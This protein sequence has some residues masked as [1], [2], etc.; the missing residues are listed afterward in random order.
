MF[1]NW[2]DPQTIWLNVTNAALGL[3]MVNF[4]TLTTVASLGSATSLLV[5]FLVNVGAFRVVTE[6]GW[7]RSLI[8]LS[9]LA[10]LFAVVVWVAYTLK[11]APH[12][13]GIFI[14]FLLIAL[15]AEGLMQRFRR[16]KIGTQNQ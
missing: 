9:I 6:S 4:L 10:C 7:T 15:I 13:L 14:S 16:R 12:S 5:Y 1:T 11:Y 2:G 8:F 3:I